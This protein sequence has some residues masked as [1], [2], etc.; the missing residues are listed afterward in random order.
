MFI[1]DQT[2]IKHIIEAAQEAIVF[3][4]SRERKD[5]DTDRQLELSL[6]KLL[7]IIGEAARGISDDL[8][9]KYPAL[10]AKLDSIDF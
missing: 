7:E 10:L 2:R 9:D 4:K 3:A 6:T 5:L 8:K 1:D